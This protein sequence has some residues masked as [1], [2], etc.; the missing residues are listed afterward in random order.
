MSRPVA[1]PALLRVPGRAGEQKAA[2]AAYVENL[3]I[4]APVVE[5]EHEVA[6]AELADLDVEEEEAALCD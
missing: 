1:W 3:L 6:V 4:A 5:A 2:T